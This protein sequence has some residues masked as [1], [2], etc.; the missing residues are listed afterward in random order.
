MF[1]VLLQNETV[2]ID[3]IHMLRGRKTG[4]VRKHR[5]I[6]IY[7]SSVIRVKRRMWACRWKVHHY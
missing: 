3:N 6:K 5:S 7:Q 4:P 1:T 2:L